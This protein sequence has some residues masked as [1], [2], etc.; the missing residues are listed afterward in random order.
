MATKKKAD[1]GPFDE[2]TE[3]LTDHGT[4]GLHPGQT[5]SF[6]KDGSAV[7]EGEGVVA[8]ATTGES[9]EAEASEE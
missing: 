5:L 9:A 6:D 3:V 8:V 1:H 4:F 7:I 2:Y